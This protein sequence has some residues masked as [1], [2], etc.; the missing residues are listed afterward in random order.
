MTP[1]R[2]TLL[3]WAG[4]GGSVGTPGIRA[5]PW[6]VTQGD[7]GGTP[8]TAGLGDPPEVLMLLVPQE[9][10]FKVWKIPRNAGSQA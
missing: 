7:C 5:N 6:G 4:L 8:G 9:C 2:A 3:G 10:Q 1:N